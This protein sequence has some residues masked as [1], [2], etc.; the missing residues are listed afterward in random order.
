MMR[1]IITVTC[2]LLMGSGAMAQV[3]NPATPANLARSLSKAFGDVYEKVSPGVVV[4]EAEVPEA[5]VPPGSSGLYQF[6]M[7]DPRMLPPRGY[8]YS[9]ELQQ[10][11][12][13]IMTADGYILTNGHVIAGAARDGITVQL[14]D[15][16]RFPAKLVGVDRLS[17]LAVIKIDADDLKPAELGDSDKARVGEFAF[18]LGAP[19]DLR[20][21]FTYGIISAKGRNEITDSQEYE[22]YIQTDASINPGNS[23]GPLVD[24][25]GRVIGVNTLINGMNRGLG[26]AIPINIAKKIATQLISNG[27]ALRPWIGLGMA[28][29]QDY[30]LLRQQRPELNLPKGVLITQVNEAAP[31]A[32]SG[33]RA[34]DVILAVDGTTV[35]SPHQVQKA[36]L[37]KQIGESVVLDI[38]RNQQVQ[39]VSV[40]TGER[41]PDGVRAA[42]FSRQ[43]WP[44]NAPA[45][46]L[47]VPNPNAPQ[48]PSTQFQGD[49][50]SDS[51][52][53][54][55]GIVTKTLTADLAIANN[56]K[57]EEGALVMYV[58]E[59]SPAS[60]AGIQEGDVIT[61]IDSKRVRSDADVQK[62][63]D[64]AHGEGVLVNFNRGT[65]PSYAI[66]KF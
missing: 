22:E 6:F 10:G 45:P 49:A 53:G 23:G 37:D 60:A 57:A 59:G 24:I 35:E 7:Q 48:S 28:R 25:D 42:S 26:F 8:G 64:A 58:E 66:L 63:L 30:D 41:G 2:A 3:G 13:F 4:I 16:R 50:Q 38:W 9:E 15:G 44:Q 29:D 12:G 46:Q 51:I 17:D 33:L 11:S 5:A 20:Y 62:L 19:F 21:T 65:K 27:Q 14:F 52:A 61:S 32:E 34:K 31:A 56:L 18:A 1:Y 47:Q 43:T 39:K 54:A 40:R 55:A 36:I